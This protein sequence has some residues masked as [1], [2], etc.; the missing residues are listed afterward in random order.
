MTMI[1]S[2][3][4]I[5]YMKPP[6]KITSTITNLIAEISKLLGSLE[7]TTLNI[8]GPKLRKKNKI[9][10][11]KSTLAIEGH[12]FTEDQITAVL[13]NKKVLGSSKEVLEVKNAIELYEMIDQFESH[14]TSDFLKAHKVLMKGLVDNAGKYRAKNVGVFSGTKVK[15]IAPKPIFVSELIT[16]TFSWMKKEKELHPLILSSIIHYEIE[17][18]HPFEDGNGR[19]GRFWQALILK[20]YDKFFKYVPVESLIEKNQI[21][22][23]KA[24]EMSDKAGDSTA[25]VEFMLIVI[26]ESLIEMSSELMGITN[27]YEDRLSK[28]RDYFK[29]KQF[30]RKDYMGLFKNI[31]SATASRDLKDGVAQK[32][33]TK[34]GQKN[35][36]SYPAR[37]T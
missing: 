30:S 8:P 25:F 18:I 5:I 19:M 24:L 3:D 27:T 34:N 4:T 31:S 29:D 21:K 32:I 10:T 26:K 7:A 12:T 2:Y 15:H 6:F 13:E 22:Y 9:K 28:G 20:E 37:A 14:K 36:G 1:V 16:N 35:P 11:I 23:Y 17:F 33:L